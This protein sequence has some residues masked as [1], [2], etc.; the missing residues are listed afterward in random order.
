M[1]LFFASPC[2][3]CTTRSENSNMRTCCCDQFCNAG[4]VHYA[5]WS[6]RRRSC[7]S[8]VV[9]LYI[10]AL[11][12]STTRSLGTVRLSDPTSMAD[13]DLGFSL[14][15]CSQIQNLAH[16]N[17][18]SSSRMRELED[19]AVYKHFRPELTRISAICKF[20]YHIDIFME[21]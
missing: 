2:P 19:M 6:L 15:L 3:V 12:Q 10:R 4:M 16:N 1:D 9:V 20:C 18:Y 7:L 14:S 5:S 21:Y 11:V 17:G 13:K 8:H